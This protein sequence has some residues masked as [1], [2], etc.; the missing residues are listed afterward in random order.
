MANIGSQRSSR[1]SASGKSSAFNLS[2]LGYEQ[3]FQSLFS[4]NANPLKGG[5]MQRARSKRAKSF[6]SASGLIPS[7]DGALKEVRSLRRLSAPLFPQ[8]LAFGM[9]ST[10]ELREAASLSLGHGDHAVNDASRSRRNAHSRSLL[11]INDHV[12][13]APANTANTL[14][15]LSCPLLVDPP[16]RHAMASH[17]L[18][19]GNF[20]ISRRARWITSKRDFAR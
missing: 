20:L 9:A 6:Q 4:T 10:G 11:D 16:T 17:S 2:N 18:G 5:K 14:P 1:A 12:S 7:V 19:L 3:S 13:L 15:R 8:G